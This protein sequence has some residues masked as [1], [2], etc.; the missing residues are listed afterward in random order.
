MS[1]SIP[2][3]LC[4]FLFLWLIACKTSRKATLSK[5]KEPDPTRFWYY[6]PTYQLDTA[7]SSL[8][9]NSLY[10]RI[11]K[12]DQFG[13]IYKMFRFFPDGLVLAY[14]VYNSPEKVLRQDRQ[15]TGNIH[16]YYQTRADS[17]FFT[18][19]VYYEHRPIFYDGQVHADSLVLHSRN[20]KSGEESVHTY[21]LYKE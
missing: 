4:V 18:T 9:T 19:K 15:S 5:D 7:N 20:Q 21:Y 16:G 2:L 12:A 1:R 6:D 13:D 3:F 10:F 8:Q 11:V 14:I 17:V